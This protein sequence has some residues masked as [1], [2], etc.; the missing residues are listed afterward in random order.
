MHGC[1]ARLQPLVIIVPRSVCSRPALP[2]R[3]SGGARATRRSST[4]RIAP[5]MTDGTRST[6]PP[7]SVSWVFAPA[8]RSIRD[9]PRPSS[10]TSITSPGGGPLRVGPT[11]AGSGR[12]PVRRDEVIREPRTGGKPRPVIIHARVR[13]REQAREA[14]RGILCILLF[15]NNYKRLYAPRPV[16][17]RRR[18][19][20]VACSSAF[21]L[22]AT[23]DA[24]A[25]SPVVGLN[26]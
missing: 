25:G 11:A 14:C 24:T 23:I 26:G 7:S 13:V 15:Q 10:G 22:M 6:G 2:S 17:R 21:R 3:L 9:S 8:S 4:C 16:A 19:P 5:A 1:S 18:S 20:P 12:S